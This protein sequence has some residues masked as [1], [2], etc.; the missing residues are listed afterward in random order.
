MPLSADP[1]AWWSLP[2]DTNHAVID[3]AVT[4]ANPKGPANIGQAKFIAKRALDVLNTV[5]SALATQIRDRLTRN[6]PK[7]SSPDELQPAILDFDVPGDPPPADWHERQHASLLIGQLK[8]M[9]APFY[10]ILHVAAPLWLDNESSDPA[11]QGQLQLNATKDHADP[12]NY[13]PWSADPGDDQNQAVATIGQ[14]KAVFSLRFES[15]NAVLDSDNDGLTNAQ[16]AAYHT[17]PHNPDTDG[18][19]MPD[20]WE[21]KWGLDPLNP[22]D[23]AA[24][25]DGDNLSNLEEYLA[26]TCPTGIYR[27]EVLPL[28]A[29]PFFHSA[30]DD[31]SVVMQASQNW[32]PTTALERI[33][34]PDPSGNRTI[35][36][37]PPSNWHPLDTLV[38]DLIADGTLNE[39]DTLAPCCLE[40]GNGTYRGFDTNAG[41]LIL[42][43]PGYPV[44]TLPAE[45]SWQAINNQ[46]QAVGISE[47]SVPAAD[48][49][50]DHI[51]GDLLFYF[52]DDYTNTIPM[53][54]VWFPAAEFPSIQAF[55]DNGDALIHRPMTNPDGSA[56]YEP[57]LLKDHHSPFTL[58]RQPAVAG[59]SIV[60]LSPYKA[61]MLG[62]GPKPFQITPDGTPLLLEALQIAT[63]PGTQA[64]ALA[65]LYP[66]PLVP[67]HIAS[68]GRIT[69]TTTDANNQTTLL[70]IIP[71][72]DAN[73]NGMMDD[74]ERRFANMLLDSGKSQADWGD[75]YAEMVAGNLNPA[76]DY[77]GE[78]ITAGDIATLFNHPTNQLSPDGIEMQ[79]QDRRNILAWG[80]HIP[81]AIGQPEF[82]EGMYYCDSDGYFGSAF[83]ITSFDQLQPEFLATQIL[84]ALWTK[85]TTQQCLSQFCIEEPTDDRNYTAYSG[86]IW[87]S[88]TRLA[89]NALSDRDR[90]R[91]YFK[92]TRRQPYP[93]DCVSIQEVVAV[94][95]EE[96]T[97]PA[98]KLL[99]D[100]IE[101]IPPV[102]AGYEY[103]VTLEP[104]QM[105]VDANRDG[106]IAFDG[107]DATTEEKPFVFWVNDD[108]DVEHLVDIVGSEIPA[109]L[110]QEDVF[111]GIK[112]SC[113]GVI[114]CVRDLEDF[115]RLHLSVGSLADD[116]KNERLSL[117][118][119]FVQTTGTPAIKVYLAVEKDGGMRYLL[120][121]SVGEAQIADPIY[122]TARGTVNASSDFRFPSHTWNTLSSSNPN[123][124]FIFEGSEEG[125]G[126]LQ[127]TL[128]K[129]T[130][131]LGTCGSVWIEL[132]NIKQMYQRWN[133][134]EVPAP[135]IAPE[136]WPTDYAT[137]DSD[138]TDPPTPQ[139]DDEKDFVLF[140]HGW[141][142]SKQEKRAFAETAYKR[143][144]QIGYKGRFG[145]FFWPNYYG[146]A[147]KLQNFD[148]SE[149][150]AWASSSALLS[151]LNQL[152]LKYPGRVNLTAH[153]MGN[154]VASEALHKA[155]K[156]VVKNYV[157][158]QAALAA[159]VFKHNPDISNQ[160]DQILAATFTGYGVKLP[161]AKKVV[162][163]NVYAY[164]FA[165][166]REFGYCTKQYP[167]MGKP[168]MAGI[169]GAAKWHN[170]MNPHD[171]ALGLWIYNQSQKPL[172]GV[173]TFSEYSAR[174]YSY[175]YHDGLGRIWSF[176]V[177][178]PGFSNDHG[179]YIG[180]RGNSPDCT[181]EIFSY[182][183]Q[184][185]SNPTGRQ[186][187]VGGV[188][189]NDNQLNLSDFGEFHPGHSA[190]FL[191]SI[192]K[193][194]T[195]WHDLLNSCKIKHIKDLYTNL[196]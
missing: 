191:Q 32:D 28:G 86:Q 193:R 17:D 39:G 144:W 109:T 195:Y 67:H 35:E 50:P 156:V 25:P 180:A 118:L 54:D 173:Y 132:K 188:F 185:R 162:T 159:D 163:P 153:S 104:F 165:D 172:S 120:K 102:V 96:P 196:P 55:S 15:L 107:T 56:G 176:W 94:D 89:A 93:Y 75:L 27:I 70:Q 194:W 151:L 187:N 155:S 190:Q 84:S 119:E 79:Y 147:N 29:N 62:S 117:G 106:K 139:T 137:Q 138:S 42:R 166:T 146:K 41:L 59:E 85:S 45:I 174:D 157:A 101:L 143:M 171:W 48:G 11:Q 12:T 18:D 47:R 184:A 9:A 100:W 61:R 20:A 90:T 148:G 124:H 114:T 22:A 103:T 130:E 152:N 82:N 4:D 7:P 16:E 110:E 160:W 37:V 126:K 74:W 87:H 34:A 19:G 141:N 99:S 127:I 91:C 40:S 178:E 46:G 192:C 129:D 98:G 145:A 57:Y 72:N 65:S 5:D 134:N 68:D 105:A 140:V 69:L 175:G 181:Y 136:V 73:R 77:T 95:S 8:A 1:P 38:A 113:D 58:V 23:A 186:W 115:T 111:D 122:N 97:I 64:V 33:T 63:N 116:L 133:A 44:G 49:V 158:S 164:Y 168:Y 183:A 142:M 53:P 66:N 52:G 121:N 128:Y 21:I 81:A 123:A 135:G 14:L 78:G 125:K 3:P 150:R 2:D 30:A 83:G 6:Q 36:P 88:R 24:D 169:G 108:H 177:D 149:H 76:T 189:L 154:V 92:V 13:Y 26:G 179:I 170:Y 80:M 131:K 43:E 71:N 161:Y 31:G 112:D 51:E 60:A 167:E 10:D 182:C